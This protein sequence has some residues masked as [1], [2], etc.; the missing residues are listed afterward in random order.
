MEIS[1]EFRV[2]E[3][4][5]SLDSLY[6]RHITLAVELFILSFLAA[7]LIVSLFLKTS[8]ISSC[9]SYDQ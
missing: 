8:S 3:L 5:F 1:L 6:L 9:F 7:L 4:L 2:I